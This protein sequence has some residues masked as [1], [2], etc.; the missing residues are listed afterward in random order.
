MEALSISHLPQCREWPIYSKQRVQEVKEE[1]EW[2]AILDE[3]PTLIEK[4]ND[5]SQEFEQEFSNRNL[6]IEDFLRLHWR[7]R[8]RQVLRQV[9]RERKAVDQSYRKELRGIGVVLD[10]ESEQDVY[11][12]PADTFEWDDDSGDDD[13]KGFW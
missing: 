1:E 6:S 3:D 2:D 12:D 9:R 5:L 7:P 11:Y 13:W 10:D 4:L 8:M